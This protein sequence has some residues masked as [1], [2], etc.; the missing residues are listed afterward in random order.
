MKERSGMIIDKTSER[1]TDTSSMSAPHINKNDL[2]YS[3]TVQ[4]GN[5]KTLT[6]G[7]I[8]I[9]GTP[10]FCLSIDDEDG[11][12][13]VQEIELNKDRFLLLRYIINHPETLKRFGIR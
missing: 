7:T 12:N 5:G 4:I 1:D 6:M 8:T 10:V 11:V 9:N 2:E 13:L 3:Y